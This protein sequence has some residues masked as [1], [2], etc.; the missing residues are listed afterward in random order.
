MEPSLPRWS[1][2]MLRLAAVYNLLWGTAVVLFPRLPFEFA[3]MDTPNYPCLAQCIGMIVGVYG[4][5]YWIASWDPVRHWPMI[6]VGLL[7]KILGPIGFVWCALRGELPWIAGL[8]IL[9]NDLAWWWP[10]GVTLSRA[11]SIERY[12]VLQIR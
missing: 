10:F 6:L 7:G 12:R 8:T 4:V 5:G 9:T 3:G 1:N 11:W 2:A